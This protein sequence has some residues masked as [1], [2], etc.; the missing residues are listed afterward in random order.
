MG[1]CFE[2]VG[3]GGFRGEIEGEVERIF[4]GGDGGCVYYL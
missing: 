3:I 1:R 2:I 4:E